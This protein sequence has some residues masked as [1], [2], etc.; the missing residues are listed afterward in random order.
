[1]AAAGRRHALSAAVD[2]AA[3]AAAIGKSSSRV[4]SLAQ[5]KQQR[6]DL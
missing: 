6:R 1:V 3:I 4:A 2:S 5:T